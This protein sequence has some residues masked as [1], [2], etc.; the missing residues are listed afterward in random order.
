MTAETASLPSD[1]AIVLNASAEVERSLTVLSAPESLTDNLAR[2]LL[3][4]VDADLVP[5][6]LDALHLCDFVIERNSEWILSPHARQYLQEQLMKQR[7]LMLTIH[8]NLLRLSDS[9]E[10]QAAV[11]NIPRYLTV[12]PGKAY[13]SAFIDAQAGLAEYSRIA[14]AGLPGQQWL[15][16]KLAREQQELRVL[17]KDVFELDFLQG[18]VYYREGR[19]VE[20]IALLRRVASAPVARVEVAIAAHLVGRFDGKRHR[21]QK[22]ELLLDRSLEINQVLKNEFGQAQVLHTLGQL[23]GRNRNRTGEAEQ[24]LR[25]SLAIETELGDGQPQALHQAQVIHTLGQLIGRNRNRTG[26]AE[27]LLRQSLAI[28]TEA[29]NA[30]GQAQVLHTLGQLIGRDRKRTDEA[31]QLL[32]QSL[33]IETE[34]GNRSS[35][36]AVLHTLGQLIG[37][38]RKRTDEAEQLLG[39]SLNL[40]E[41]LGIKSHQAQVLYTMGRIRAISDP[42]DAMALL[43][44]SLVLNQELHNHSGI[45]IVNRQLA[46]LREQGS[47]EGR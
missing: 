13:H 20:A 43:E 3:A 45:N 42:D 21:P 38:D 34:L 26:E 33:A 6:L 22:A 17:P 35:E 25:Q 24:L 15:A 44:R 14:L 28:E 27:Q 12:G 29:G 1:V 39:K 40:G 23:I 4:E 37:R 10:L 36:A 16:T 7:E 11:E 5:R 46:R 31:E 32:R 18:M 19:T 41:S 47:L 9:T 8:A 30:Y 2:Y